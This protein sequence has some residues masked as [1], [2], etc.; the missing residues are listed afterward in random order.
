MSLDGRRYL[1][2]DLEA[3]FGAGLASRTCKLSVIGRC[4]V[5]RVGFGSVDVSITV[6]L[7]F[8]G[9]MA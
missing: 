2:V 3:V 5:L 4:L 6:A 8:I 9:A 1:G 7:R